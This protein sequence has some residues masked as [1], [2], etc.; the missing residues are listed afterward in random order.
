MS[1]KIKIVRTE[2]AY[3]TPDL[4]ED[5]YVN[6]NVETLEQALAIDLKYLQEGK[7]NIY[8]LMNDECAV[9][10]SYGLEIVEVDDNG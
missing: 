5:F 6:H 7:A 3:Y 4:E 1:K 10:I 8:E 2:T 9:D